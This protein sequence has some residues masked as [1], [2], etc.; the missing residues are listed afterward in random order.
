M[1]VL[2]PSSSMLKL[3][4][5]QQDGKLFGHGLMDLCSLRECLVTIKPGY[6]LE[7]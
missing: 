2:E 3:G 7:S 5:Y 4:L 1:F 6:K